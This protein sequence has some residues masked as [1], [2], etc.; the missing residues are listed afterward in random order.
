L[1]GLDGLNSG[2]ALNHVMK[3][4]HMFLMNALHEFDHR[5]GFSPLQ[6]VQVDRLAIPPNGSIAEWH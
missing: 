3:A 1:Y 2:S 5:A 4:Y 6:V